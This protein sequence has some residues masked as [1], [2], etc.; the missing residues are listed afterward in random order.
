MIN[1]YKRLIETYHHTLDLM[2]NTALQTI[3]DHIGAAL[4]YSRA[5]AGYATGNDI[6]DVGSGVGLPGIVIAATQ[7][8]KTIIL[9]ERRQRRV[10][11]LRIVISQLRLENVIVFADDVRDLEVQNISLITAQ[12]VA[13]FTS[14]YCLTRHI[15]ADQV[16]LLSRKG[17]QW[18]S[19]LEQLSGVVDVQLTP[20]TRETNGVV[21]CEELHPHGTLVGVRVPGGRVCP[22]SVLST[23]KAG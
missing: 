11:F 19:E 16:I 20:V 2:S 8:E 14:L 21:V 4:V 12:A 5:V 3:D 9:V 18:Q 15:H 6:V 1:Q 7:P 23:K 13:D 22:P 10:S 17:G